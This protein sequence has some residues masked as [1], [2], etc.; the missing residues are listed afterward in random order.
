MSKNTKKKNAI[1]FGAIAI[2]I[3]IVG[4][5]FSVWA[6]STQA[7]AQA[8]IGEIEVDGITVE[9]GEDSEDELLE[10]SIAGRPGS[11]NLE[12]AEGNFDPFE[13]YDIGDDDDDGALEN[14]EYVATVYLLN[15]AELVDAGMR[16]L[17]LEMELVDVDGNEVDTGAVTLEGG[18]ATFVF[19]AEDI[20][21]T[22]QITGG[23]FGTYPFADFEDVD[24][25]E[26]IIDVEPGQELDE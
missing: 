17:T 2:A 3:L 4:G 23:A 21:A 12:D 18:R 6:L 11:L 15:G 1:R 26:F 7:E 14:Y 9:P 20:D 19:D 8:G 5:A 16:H 25:V 22:I 24:N 10:D 13:L